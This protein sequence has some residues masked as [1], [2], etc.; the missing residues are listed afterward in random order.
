MAPATPLLRYGFDNQPKKVE[1]PGIT[2]N[3]EEEK[4]PAKEKANK[5]ENNF[6]IFDKIQ[7]KRKEKKPQGTMNFGNGITNKLVNKKEELKEEPK[8]DPSNNMPIIPQKIES[9][10]NEDKKSQGNIL[11]KIIS[12]S[13]KKEEA[14]PE[15]RIKLDNT[16]E[17]KPHHSDIK[18]NVSDTVVN[19]NEEILK[20]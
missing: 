3:K 11:N 14:P 13:S 15:L 19:I 16:P 18:L 12:S 5:V 8:P 4:K 9:I 17:T 10:K 20:E 2:T 6:D 7:E 1:L